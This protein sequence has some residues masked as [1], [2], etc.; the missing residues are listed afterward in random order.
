VAHHITGRF[1]RGL[2][3][4]SLEARPVEEEELAVP[5]EEEQEFATKAGMFMFVV[6]LSGLIAVI[7]CGVTGNIAGA[8]A[9]LGVII[10]ATNL[11]NGMED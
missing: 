2:P 4:L 10:W 7:A 5:T 6:S 1:L 8:I 9:S 3:R 11:L